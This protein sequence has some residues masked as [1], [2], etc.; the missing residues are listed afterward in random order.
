M[1]VSRRWCEDWSPRP[2][3]T[4]WSTGRWRR[5]W[6][7]PHQRAA[8]WQASLAPHRSEYF[9]L[10]TDRSWSRRCATSSSLSQPPRPRLC[11]ASTRRPDPSSRPQPADAAM[12]GQVERQ[13]HDYRR[14]E[15]PRCSPLSTRHWQ[16]D[17]PSPSAATRRR[18]PA[19]L[20]RIDQEVPRVRPAPGAGQP[21]TTRRR[22]SSA[23]CCSTRF[24]STHPDL[25]LVINQ[26]NAGCELT[27]SSCAAACTAAPGPG[28]RHPALSRHLQRRSHPCV[29]KTADEIL[30]ASNL[31][32]TNLRT[33]H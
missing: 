6:A 3:R 14:H 19:F 7:Q 15:P 25:L 33:G 23:G 29:V 5:R 18:V 10:S 27:A 24:T 30:P 2:R 16:G 9:K 26:S 20:D 1:T 21:S 12:P 31:L 32:S 4:H 22:R 13:T 11:S 28:G 17:R 8:I